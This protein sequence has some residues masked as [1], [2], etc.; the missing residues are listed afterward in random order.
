MELHKVT[1]EIELFYLGEK[2]DI[3][4]LEEPI[5][6]EL[7]NDNA[8]ITSIIPVKPGMIKFDGILNSIPWGKNFNDLTIGEILELIGEKETAEKQAA[9]TDAEQL[10]LLESDT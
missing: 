10:L 5:R 8:K 7:D 2:P 4:D 6:G 9:D 3:Y 1:V